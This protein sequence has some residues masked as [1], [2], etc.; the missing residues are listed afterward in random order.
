MSAT[1]FPDEN[2]ARARFWPAD[3]HVIGKD[4]IRFHA[5]YWPAFLMSAGLALP[6]RVY[7]HGFLFNRGE[8]MSKSVG[9]VVDPFSLVDTYGLDALRYFLLREVPFGRDGSYS[10]DAIVAR[11]NADLANDLGNL[12]QRSLSMVFKNLDGKLTTPTALV[13]ADNVILEQARALL[14]ECREAMDIQAPHNALNAIWNVVSEANRY[15]AAQEPWA[16]KK[17]DPQRMS[18]VLYVTAEIVRRVAVLSQP[19]M[20]DAAARLLD[21]LAV[22]SEERNFDALDTAN[23]LTSG[24]IITKPEGIFPRFVEPV[25]VN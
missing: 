24:T 3:V 12:A 8:K 7:A 14:P 20:P 9:N 11:M 23:T 17:T 1:G 18:D 16:L 19:F 25:A 6:K 4:I 2:D 10:H 22:P 21:A 13:E 5:V 15:F